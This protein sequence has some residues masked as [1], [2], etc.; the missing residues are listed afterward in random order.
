MRLQNIL[1]REGT[2]LFQFNERTALPS[3][4][5]LRE[6][7]SLMGDQRKHDAPRLP[8]LSLFLGTLESLASPGIPVLR[9]SQYNSHRMM[10]FETFL[11]LFPGA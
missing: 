11:A 5:N 6:P 3:T 9:I 7:T 4:Q 1:F 8:S 2:A 10:R